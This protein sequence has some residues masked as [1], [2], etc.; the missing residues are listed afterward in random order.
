MKRR[1]GRVASSATS[2]RTPRKQLVGT[3]QFTPGLG[4]AGEDRRHLGIRDQPHLGVCRNIGSIGDLR[5]APPR[6]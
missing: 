5:L 1:L 6:S 4:G 3:I 2:R